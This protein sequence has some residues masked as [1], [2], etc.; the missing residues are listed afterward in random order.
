MTIGSADMNVRGHHAERAED[1]I[2][3]ETSR[4]ISRH[5]EIEVAAAH[6]IMEPLRT[7]M[8]YLMESL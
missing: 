7:E 5:V 3:I 8:S 6:H 1:G 4:D 2:P